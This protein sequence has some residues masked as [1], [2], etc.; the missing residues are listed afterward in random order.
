MI[1]L[2][3]YIIVFIIIFLVLLYKINIY[4]SYNNIVIKKYTQAKSIL[5]ILL[6]FCVGIFFLTNILLSANF[7]H[8]NISNKNFNENLA[9]VFKTTK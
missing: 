3:H 9:I 6:Y 2:L 5:N 4:F 1:V 8:K 7:S